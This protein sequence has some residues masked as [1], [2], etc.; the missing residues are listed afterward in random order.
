MVTTIVHNHMN[1]ATPMDVDK[2]YI[3]SMDE[4]KTSK[5]ETTA[6]T[7]EE[8]GQDEKQYPMYDEE[9]GFVFFIGKATEVGRPMGKAKEKENSTACATTAENQ[10]TGA[11]IAGRKA[12]TRETRKEKEARRTRASTTKAGTFMEAKVKDTAK[13]KASTRSKAKHSCRSRSQ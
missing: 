10:D 12:K 13:A 8:E 1:A 9:G 3:M 5:E 4:N 11:A 7:R 6:G 2:K